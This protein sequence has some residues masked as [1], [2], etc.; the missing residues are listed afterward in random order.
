MHA[1][2]RT[3]SIAAAIATLAAIPF[4][5]VQAATAASAAAAPIDADKQKLIDKVLTLWHP[6]IDIVNAARRPAGEMMQQAGNALQQARVP[7]DKAEKAMKDIGAD[8]QKYVDAVTPL[9][10][11]SAK[12]NVGPVAGPLL[13][14]TFTSDELKQLIALLESPVKAKFETLAPQIDRALSDKVKPEIGAE[15]GKDITAM[16]QSA[17]AKLRAAAT[18][19][20]GASN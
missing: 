9:A 4:A 3:L 5:H 16:N 11:A 19:A 12:K 17:I 10:S 13:A 18:P 2:Q 20:S 1:F 8:A 14:Q 6:E 15:L 7:K